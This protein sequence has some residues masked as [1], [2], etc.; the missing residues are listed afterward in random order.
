M[1]AKKLCDLLL[2]VAVNQKGKLKVQPKPSRTI[3]RF[4]VVPPLG[5]PTLRTIRE[6]WGTLLWWLGQGMAKTWVRYL[7]IGDGYFSRYGLS[8]YLRAMS[9]CSVSDPALMVA[10]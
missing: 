10:W 2:T 5:S 9:A 6:R 8:R 3:L 1:R 4:G 7:P